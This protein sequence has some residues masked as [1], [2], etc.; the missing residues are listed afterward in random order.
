MTIADR[1]RNIDR[2]YGID[3]LHTNEKHAHVDL[4]L[5]LVLE[6]RERAERWRQWSD[7]ARRQAVTLMLERRGISWSEELITFEVNYYT[8]KW[9]Q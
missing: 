5:F 6:P 3:Q 4:D 9:G 7:V 1:Q 2:I 8:Q